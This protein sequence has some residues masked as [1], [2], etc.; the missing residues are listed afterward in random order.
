MNEQSKENSSKENLF[1]LLKTAAAIIVAIVV[2]YILIADPPEPGRTPSQVVYSLSE[3]L[4]S[5]NFPAVCGS[6]SDQGEEQ[7]IDL[8]EKEINSLNKSTRDKLIKSTPSLNVDPSCQ[9]ALIWQKKLENNNQ[10]TQSL[11]ILASADL[12]QLQQETDSNSAIVTVPNSESSILFSD[13]QSGVNLGQQVQLSKTRNVWKV[14]SVE[15][16]VISNN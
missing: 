4:Q 1:N 13:D 9:T 7:L 2:A 11:Y 14:D 3:D 8:T 5:G 12:D 15:T 10:S 16:Q 6:L